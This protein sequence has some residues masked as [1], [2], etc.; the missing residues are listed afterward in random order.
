MSWRVAVSVCLVAFVVTLVVLGSVARAALATG[1]L[2]LV[3]SFAHRRPML[4]RRPRG[5]PDPPQV[6]HVP[7]CPSGVYTFELWPRDESAKDAEAIKAGRSGNV[8]SRLSN[9][10][11][12]SDRMIRHQRVLRTPYEKE[13]EAQI[14]RDLLPWRLPG[15]RAVEL[16]RPCPEVRW[17]LHTLFEQARVVG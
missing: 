9:Y 6:E 5:V 3:A 17:Y 4:G 8:D 14:H 1:L 12:L 11:T 2:V 15:V 13:V 7:G 10:V 16:Y